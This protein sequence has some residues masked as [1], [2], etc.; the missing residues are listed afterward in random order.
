M[1]YHSTQSLKL[2]KY[3]LQLKSY[4]ITACRRV[5]YFVVDIIR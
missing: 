2:Y 1:S 4:P 5:T 3:S